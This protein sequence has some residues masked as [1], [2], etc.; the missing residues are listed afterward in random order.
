[1]WGGAAIVHS[2]RET[3]WQPWS[4]LE[5][6]NCYSF[7]DHGMVPLGSVTL[8]DSIQVWTGTLLGSECKEEKNKSNANFDKQNF[9]NQPSK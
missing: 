2:K 8:W 4:L 9:N 3:L 5:Q 6:Q 7:W 1:M